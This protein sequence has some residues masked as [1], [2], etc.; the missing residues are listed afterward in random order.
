[1]VLMYRTVLSVLWPRR[2]ERAIRMLTLSANRK[3]TVFDTTNTVT[4]VNCFRSPML[5]FES[6]FLSWLFLEDLSGIIQTPVTRYLIP[7]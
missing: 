2:M 4:T 3:T 7:A 1:M 5:L 6:H